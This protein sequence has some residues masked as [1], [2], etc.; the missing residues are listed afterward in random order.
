MNRIDYDKLFDVF[1]EPAETD[2]YMIK[3][4]FPF[5]MYAS[6]DKSLKLNNFYGNAYIA[7]SVI[8]SLE[9]VYNYYGH[10]GIKKY[11]LNSWGGC[12]SIRKSRGSNKWSTHAW[13]M[14]I[15][16]LPELGGYGQPAM[17]PYP[18]V[19]IF[20]LHGFDW[21]GDWSYKDAMHFTAVNE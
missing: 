10:D 14:A 4:R 19:E 12:A 11:N 1:G 13:G 20:K 3:K 2:K 21:G 7:D 5:P 15:D 8:R 6:W 18:I 17:T 16:Y 9:E